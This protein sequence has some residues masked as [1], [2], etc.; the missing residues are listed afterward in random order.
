MKKLLPILFLL[1]IPSLLLGQTT[2][3][4]GPIVDQRGN[5]WS[6][7]TVTAFFSPT[8]NTPGPFNWS[9]GSFNLAP[10]TVTADS[11]GNFSLVL[12][13]NSAIA[14]SGSG[15]YFSVCPNATLPCAVVTL[16][17]SG[18]TVNISTAITNAGTWPPG[19]VTTTQIAKFYNVNQTQGC[20]PVNQGGMGYNT[21][22]SIMYVCTNSGFQPFATVGG[23]PII[24][25]PSGTQSITQPLNTDFNFIVS[26]N[27]KVKI[28]GNSI[29]PLVPLP[30]ILN[31]TTFTSLAGYTPNGTTP[32]VSG[33]NLIFTGGAQNFTQT[34][35]YNYYT[36]LPQWS[37]AMD[38][39]TGAASSTS[40]GVG[41]GLRSAQ[42]SGAYY[43]I[44]ANMDMTSN[45]TRGTLSIQTP[46]AVL[47]SSS[48]QLTFSAGDTIQLTLTR[49]QDLMTATVS[50]L[51]TGSAAVTVTYQFAFTY[52][53]AVTPN[54]GKF[55][56]FNFGGTQTVTNLAV[57]TQAPKNADV[58]FVGDSKTA[59]YYAGTW[60]NIWA[61]QLQ[62]NVKSFAL[63]GGSDQ[64]PDVL[65]DLPEIISIHPS[66]VVLNIG[67]NDICGG[68]GIPL[69]TTEAN[70]ASIVSQLQASN[71]AVYHLLPLYE[72][73]GLCNQSAF[74]SWIQ[75]N[76]PAANII[77]S[78]ME[79]YAGTASNV[80]APDNVHPNAFA[81]GLIYNAVLST[82]LKNGVSLNFE[83]YAAVPTV[84]NAVIAPNAS[85]TGT[86]DNN[87]T[88]GTTGTASIANVILSRPAGS[89]G[90]S[91]Y[92][93]E[94]GGVFLWGWGQDTG[95]SATLCI[96][97]DYSISTCALSIVQGNAGALTLTGNRSLTTQVIVGSDTAS[98]APG[99]SSGT[100]ATA[101]CYTG[102]GGTCTAA[103]GIIQVVAGTG[104][105]AGQQAVITWTAT[106]RSTR[107]TVSGAG[108]AAA[109][110]LLPYPSTQS[111][112]GVS[113]YTVNAPTAAMTYYYAY[114][115]AN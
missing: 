40:S 57:S 67:R 44:A 54:I 95:G 113:I 8:P 111:T 25:N 101:A 58:V 16:G 82:L 55:A 28:N 76:Y 78:G 48:T 85:S 93:T 17:L 112:T 37:M 69:P 74:T 24:T 15:W 22:N 34:L 79:N 87:F 29:N 2:T 99:V 103:S 91:V 108:G 105:A 13:N 7:A 70:Y 23:I 41:I 11:G 46:S 75:A 38:I 56:I 27:G 71:I 81:E 104:A 33:G 43:S 21:T 109:T 73:I 31:Q 4:S 5:T 47:A 86:L 83:S 19:F 64:T 88:V 45:G 10:P 100:G 26:G 62:N 32:A 115:C 36:T 30:T 61:T 63:A 49:N 90:A 9:G 3:V 84:P 35:D 72:P 60:L 20:P 94:V 1:L 97:Y 42:V 114:T 102:D 65:N 12:A 89:T 50:D 96:A 80:L 59:G 98:A 52:L 106:P 107:C 68:G 66:A 51:T 53:A 14:P 18:G 77:D 39:I 92:A 110:S 6:Y